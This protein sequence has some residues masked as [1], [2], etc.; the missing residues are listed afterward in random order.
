MSVYQT[1]ALTCPECEAE[2][3]KSV[4]VS[5]NGNRVPAVVDEVR[6]GRFQH[7]DCPNC[8]AVLVADGP[9]IYTDFELRRWVG[10]FPRPWEGAWRILEH[11]PAR[12]F[13]RAMIDDAPPVM[14]AEAD[15]YL[16]RTVFGLPALAEKILIWDH[17]LDDRVV[18]LMKLELHRSPDG[19]ILDPDRRLR[20]AA[21]DGTDLRLGLGTAE[22]FRV[23]MTWYHDVAERIDLYAETV[24]ALGAGPYV[25]IGRAALTGSDDIDRRE[26]R[27]ASAF[28]TLDPAGIS[29]S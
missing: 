7:F 8:S 11:E 3:D 19:P 13:Q 4:C 5:L 21:C 20:F 6:T 25:D 9:L 16:V 14:R 18:E 26:I 28:A 27:A 1:R 12:S 17:G 23:P 22:V 24:D 15:G 2:F 10:C 29:S